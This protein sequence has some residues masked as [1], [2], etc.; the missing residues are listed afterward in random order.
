MLQIDQFV[1]VY[2][3]E[4]IEELRAGEKQPLIVEGQSEADVSSWDV[5]SWVVRALTGTNNHDIFKAENNKKTYNVFKEDHDVET[6]Y[7]WSVIVTR[8]KLDVLKH[9]NFGVFMVNLAKGSMMAPLWNPTGVEIGIV[10]HGHGEIQMVCPSI[11]AN[12]IECKNSRLRVE[13]GDVFVVPRYHPMAQ[14]SFNND[15]FVFMGFM[16]KQKNESPQFLSGKLSILQRLDRKVLEKSFN[17][18]N[19]TIDWIS[20]IY[21]CISCVD[22]ELAMKRKEGGGGGKWR[23]DKGER[24]EGGGDQTIETRRLVD[25]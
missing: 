3:E 5:G 7:G 10:L 22:E 18:K 6:C 12:E 14:I 16:L 11:I 25:G 15:S 19:T 13:E 23:I 24:S 21:E 20:Y 9:T 4:V 8:K 17:A 1:E 2:T